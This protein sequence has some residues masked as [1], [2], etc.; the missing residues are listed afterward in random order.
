MA[1]TGLEV[2][3]FFLVTFLIAS[4]LGIFLSFSIAEFMRDG[5]ITSRK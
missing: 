1:K 2:S 4:F 3:V 5:P